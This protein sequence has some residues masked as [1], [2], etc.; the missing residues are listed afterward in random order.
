[1]VLLYIGQHIYET[2]QHSSLN[3]KAHQIVQPSFIRYVFPLVFYTLPVSN[4]LETRVDLPSSRLTF[5]S[6]YLQVDLPSSLILTY[7]G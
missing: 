3:Y 7:L 1:M 2:T 6:T 4:H 5:K